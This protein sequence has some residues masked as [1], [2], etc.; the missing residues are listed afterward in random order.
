MEIKKNLKTQT[1]N[2]MNDEKFEMESKLEW[3]YG[4]LERMFKWGS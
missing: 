1:E 3:S 2:L 4:C